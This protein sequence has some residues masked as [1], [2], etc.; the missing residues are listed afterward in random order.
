V[1]PRYLAENPPNV[2]DASDPD[3]AGLVVA[4]ENVPA[5]LERGHLRKKSI[6]RTR[7]KNKAR[8]RLK[9]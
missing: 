6:N 7:E 8:I 4:D 9:E 3:S 2:V 1:Q 5:G